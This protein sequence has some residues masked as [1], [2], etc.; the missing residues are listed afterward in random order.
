[1]DVLLNATGAAHRE[2]VEHAIRASYAS[3]VNATMIAAGVAGLVGA[4]IV[5]V[6]LRPSRGPLDPRR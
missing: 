1:V 3:A 2:T 4:G 5:A 6:A